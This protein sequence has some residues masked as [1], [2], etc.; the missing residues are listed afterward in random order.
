MR[1]RLFTEVPSLAAPPRRRLR[2][3]MPGHAKWLHAISGSFRQGRKVTSVGT[4][5]SERAF[6]T[7]PATTATTA[8]VRRNTNAAVT[9]D[10]MI[11][12]RRGAG[13]SFRPTNLGKTA[14]LSENR[15]RPQLSLVEDASRPARSGPRPG[16]NRRRNSRAPCSPARYLADSAASRF[17]MAAARRRALSPIIMLKWSPRTFSLVKQ[18]PKSLPQPRC[19][20][21]SCPEASANTP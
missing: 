3:W 4:V 1:S 17:S 8:A 18:L 15:A 16:G 12:E 21:S 20:S 2:K 13:P 19:L 7:Q 11:S 6:P 14:G 9:D 5:T 10:R